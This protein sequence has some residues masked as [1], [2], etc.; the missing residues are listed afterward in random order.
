MIGAL[1][2]NFYAVPKRARVSVTLLFLS[3]KDYFSL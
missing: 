1:W 3:V 2:E